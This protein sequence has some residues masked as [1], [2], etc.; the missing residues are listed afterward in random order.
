MSCQ[1]QAICRVINDISK[2]KNG[3]K[4][5][6]AY[7]IK[8]PSVVNWL[9]LVASTAEN[10]TESEKVASYN[11]QTV[12]LGDD[13]DGVKNNISSEMSRKESELETELAALR[14]EDKEFHR[15]RKRG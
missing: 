15:K 1:C 8:K 2:I 9:K 4:I 11:N 14:E 6:G 13:M 12:T 7:S 10:T 3:K 5:L